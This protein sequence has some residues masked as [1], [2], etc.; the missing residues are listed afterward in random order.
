MKITKEIAKELIEENGSFWWAN[1]TRN[2]WSRKIPCIISKALGIS[3]I[4]FRTI[5]D[6]PT[7]NNWQALL[8]SIMYNTY[9][10]NQNL[11]INK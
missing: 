6:Q 11:T 4:L 2:K 3:T 8:C 7:G 5:I 1:D 10:C 9:L